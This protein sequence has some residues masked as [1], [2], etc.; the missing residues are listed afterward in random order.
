MELSQF[1]KCCGAVILHH[2]TTYDENKRKI[3]SEEWRDIMK[4]KLTECKYMKYG[5]VM[6][7]T[8]PDQ[9][10]EIAE[11][12]KFGFKSIYSFINPITYSKLTVWVFE[13]SNFTPEFENPFP[14][15]NYMELRKLNGVDQL[16]DN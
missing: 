2:L 9:E 7:I 8:N 6:A 4:R 14:N 10:E 15:S 3:S 11:L 1:K 12:K 13:L 16:G 5:V